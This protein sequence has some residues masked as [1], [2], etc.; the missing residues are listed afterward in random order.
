[1]MSGRRTRSWSGAEP[2]SDS[3]HQLPTLQDFKDYV[4]EKFK[5]RP[6][7]KSSASKEGEKDVRRSSRS[8]S[9]H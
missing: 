3:K 2:Y 4:K 7:L 8:A 5:W 9:R 6:R 1:M